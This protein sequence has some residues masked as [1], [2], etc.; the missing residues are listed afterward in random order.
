MSSMTTLTA[1]R[2]VPFRPQTKLLDFKIFLIRQGR[3]LALRKT[4]IP[5]AAFIS[6]LR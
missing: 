3:F 2:N 5:N 4:S 1:T 6:F